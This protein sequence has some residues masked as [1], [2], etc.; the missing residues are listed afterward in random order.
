MTG[1]GTVIHITSNTR[2]PVNWKVFMR[3]SSNK[4]ELFKYLRNAI[5]KANT[6]ILEGIMLITTQGQHV[7]SKLTIG[8]SCRH[9]HKKKLT[10]GSCCMFH[11]HTSLDIRNAR[12]MIQIQKMF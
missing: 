8:V 10:Q 3:V 6:G 1:S 2:V 5:I 12:S 11:M 9:V 4:Q 7:V